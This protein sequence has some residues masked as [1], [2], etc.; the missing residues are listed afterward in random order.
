V[1]LKQFPKLIAS[2]YRT[3][4]KLEATFP[5]RHFTPDGHMLGSIGEALAAYHY[6]LTLSPASAKCHDGACKG[7]LV[8][9]KATQ[10]SR[11]AI[12]SEPEHLLVL[13]LKRDGSFS[14]A[15]NGPGAPVWKL[16]AAK[17]MPKNGQHQVSLSALKV[18]MSEMPKT[19]MIPR[20][21]A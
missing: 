19:Q 13:R 8:Q 16:V 2:I 3:V 7:R 14:E 12:S 18:L 17:R 15:Y 20:R 10:R 21:R 9:V 6:R 1:D 5:G 4:E 11:I